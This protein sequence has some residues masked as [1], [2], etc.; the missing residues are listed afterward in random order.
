MLIGIGSNMCQLVQETICVNTIYRN[1]V[2][3]MRLH[4]LSTVCILA[5]MTNLQ[6]CH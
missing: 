5:C 1:E 3:W 2:D 4:H 6:V